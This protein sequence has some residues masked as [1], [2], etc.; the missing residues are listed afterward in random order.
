MN[1]KGVYHLS[2]K[3][4]EKGY[5]SD[6][7]GVYVPY[8]DK[9]Y[10][11][12]VRHNN[13][14]RPMSY[15]WIKNNNNSFELKNG[16]SRSKLLSFE[17]VTEKGK[18][19]INQ[20]ISNA[21]RQSGIT[22]GKNDY[23]DFFK[24]LHSDIIASDELAIFKDEY[25]KVPDKETIKEKPL[26]DNLKD[27]AYNIFKNGTVCDKMADTICLSY[28]GDKNEIKIL[29][30]ET[31]SLFIKGVEPI[32]INNNDDSG[33]GKTA[34]FIKLIEC[35]PPENVIYPSSLSSKVL[36]YLLP[37]LGDIPIIIVFDDC[38][39]EDLRDI[40]KV[41][42]D[43]QRKN[44]EH[45]VTGNK[46]A[47]SYKMT[48]KYLDILCNAEGIDDN[49]TLNRFLDREH[50]EKLHGNLT[51]DKG[52]VD[53]DTIRKAI[54]SKIAFNKT[55]N[56]ETSKYLENQCL[57][58]Q[59][60]IRMII[61]DN[62]IVFNPYGVKLP[63]DVLINTNP[64]IMN[65]L[66]SLIKVNTYLNPN[67][68]IITLSDGVKIKLGCK[69]DV[70]TSLKELGLSNQ[71]YK[72][73]NHQKKIKSYLED[74]KI[75][76]IE[77][78]LLKIGNLAIKDD[79]NFDDMEIDSYNKLVGFLAVNDYP[80]FKEKF[81]EKLDHI[82]KN[83]IKKS[84]K[85]NGTQIKKA[86]DTN[87]ENNKPSLTELN[88]VKVKEIDYYKKPFNIYYIPCSD[89]VDSFNLD[90]VDGFSADDKNVMIDNVCCFFDLDINPDDR[91]LLMESF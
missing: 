33:E 55:F 40:I 6:G 3:L 28:E 26:S 74:L 1:D 44:K 79:D 49:E 75:D 65:F 45:L 53:K 30:K 43:N 16:F 66:L 14:K 54:N 18:S 83:G 17:E 46:E 31:L 19:N 76:N 72:L 77:D 58:V 36:N 73:S 78:Y 62:T 37:S 51:N 27:V 32:H 41:T 68:K 47:L 59:E 85:I 15:Q 20:K 5:I 89:D 64:R 71:K 25:I 2:D 84:C 38:D 11:K 67:N 50:S 34:L 91:G 80:Y 21:G 12:L 60:A 39:F 81:K 56:V 9:Y 70:E 10:L 4:I 24:K 48:G 22:A 82:T 86:L 52:N 90:I 8:N 61:N 13:K 63:D 57:I 29:S 87:E 7:S 23:I 35:I 88:I 69:E 42:S